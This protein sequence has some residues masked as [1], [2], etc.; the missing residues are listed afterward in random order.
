MFG[1]GGSEIIV[2]L[3]IALL[4]LG[5]DKLPEA[6]RA[7]SKG[8]RELKKGSRVLTQTIENDE[9]VGGALRDIKSALRGEEPAPRPKPLKRRKPPELAEGD[10]VIENSIAGSGPEQ[11][12]VSGVADSGSAKI[13]AK[14][15]AEA[16]VEISEPKA[17]IAEAEATIEAKPEAKLDAPLVGDAKP[18]ADAKPAVR[19][20][21]MVGEA[22]PVEDEAKTAAEDLH[23]LIRPAEGTI[24]KGSETK[25]G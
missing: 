4:F 16:T 14:T 15:D 20:P 5:P 19:L 11:A 22:E 7:L 17:E 24:A 10:I 2:I 21:E 25:H 3:I 6:T 8:I 12:P 23:A 9:T 1:M 13:E 18:E